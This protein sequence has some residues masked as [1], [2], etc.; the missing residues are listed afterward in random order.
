MGKGG[1]LEPLPSF[2]PGLG[3]GAKARSPGLVVHLGIW[4]F[5]ALFLGL[6][7]VLYWGI[8][9]IQ[10]YLGKHGCTRYIGVYRVYS[11]TRVI[12]GKQGI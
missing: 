12:K 4:L 8:Q 2:P 5:Q 11:V 6:F 3:G 7:Q 10:Y 9:G 1:P